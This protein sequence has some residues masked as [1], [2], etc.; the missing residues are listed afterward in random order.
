M[1]CRHQKAVSLAHHPESG[2]HLTRPE[3]FSPSAQRINASRTRSTASRASTAST[4]MVHCS[5]PEQMSS[6]PSCLQSHPN[7]PA[8]APSAPI[9]FPD[10]RFPRAGMFC[11]G[12]GL[13]AGAA[14]WKAEWPP[15][16][17]R[18]VHRPKLILFFSLDYHRAMVR[19]KKRCSIGQ[20]R[21]ERRDK[22]RQRMGVAA[23]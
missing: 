16:P 2:S 18:G 8:L 17:S 3:T 11:F 7:L 22:V 10:P 19:K 6:D 23:R 15:P 21:R 9:T 1:S 12:K 13:A 14:K 20:V 5:V 4:A